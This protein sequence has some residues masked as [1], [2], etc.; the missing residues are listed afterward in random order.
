M[1]MNQFGHVSGI[2]PTYTCIDIYFLDIVLRQ[3]KN[4]VIGMNIIYMS[5]IQ[6]RYLFN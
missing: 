1:Y 2:I 6:K 3:K 5:F 4:Y